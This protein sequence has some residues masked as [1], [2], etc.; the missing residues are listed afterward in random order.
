MRKRSLSATGVVR[1]T[2]VR[3]GPV[4]SHPAASCALDSV[5]RQEAPARYAVPGT[6]DSQRAS[7]GD[8]SAVAGEAGWAVQRTTHVGMPCSLPLEY[9]PNSAARVVPLVAANL[10]AASSRSLLEPTRRTCRGRV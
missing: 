3:T 4:Q 9:D 6:S 8:L 5:T 10:P 7:S 2:A 1:A